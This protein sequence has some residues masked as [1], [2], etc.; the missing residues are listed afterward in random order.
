MKMKKRSYAF[1]LQS[2]SESDH[3]LSSLLRN[4][5][6]RW[7]LAYFYLTGKFAIAVKKHIQNLL[8]AKV[9]AV[10]IALALCFSLLGIQSAGLVH[11]VV[12]ADSEQHLQSDTVF[13]G[14][15]KSFSSDPHKSNLVCELLDSLLLGALAVSEPIYSD[16]FNF[17]HIHP[18]P[19]FRLALISLSS[20][21]AS[22]K[23]HLNLILSSRH[24]HPL[25]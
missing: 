22:P 2:S 7:F 12:H 20:G 23:L 17:S 16:F 21:P 25:P 10:L 19:S 5:V 11:G 13:D 14:I 8:L 6:S 4:R 24:L 18:L 1:K 3:W 15:E 9:N